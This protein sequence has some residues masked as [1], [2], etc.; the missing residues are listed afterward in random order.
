MEQ[1]STVL[2]AIQTQ[3]LSV[4]FLGIQMTRA[5]KLLIFP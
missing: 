1:D 5:R 3:M 2:S 4:K